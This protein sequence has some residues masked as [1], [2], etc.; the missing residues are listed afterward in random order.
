TCA[1]SGV[2]TYEPGELTL[3]A[4]AGTPLSKIEALLAAQGQAL[5]IEPMDDRAIRG[6]TGEPTIRGVS[7]VNVSGPRRVLA[8]AC[9]DHLLGV[10]FVDGRGRVI[11]NGGRVMKNVTG[12]DLAR[13]VA[14]S[15]GTLAVLTVV[16]LKTL[17][18][19]EAQETL[20]FPGLDSA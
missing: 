16:A 3:N 11:R 17:P 18:L 1:L 5:A 8:G 10:R 19:P 14:G 6:T 2:L 4:R 7:A 20:A 12:M 15:F 13:L 9:R